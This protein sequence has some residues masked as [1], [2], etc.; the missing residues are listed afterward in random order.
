MQPLSV[1]TPVIIIGDTH[2]GKHGVI[3]QYFSLPGGIVM[4]RVLLHDGSFIEVLPQDLFRTPPPPPGPPPP[5]QQSGPPQYLPPPYPPPPLQQSGPPPQYLPP[6][7]PPPPLQQPGPPPVQLGKKAT[8]NAHKRALSASM[9]NQEAAAATG[10]P[11]LPPPLPPLPP[12]SRVWPG[13]PPSSAQEMAAL[14]PYLEGSSSYKTLNHF[15]DYGGN[16]SKTRR[17]QSKRNRKNKYSRR[18][19]NAKSRSK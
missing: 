12:P 4:A 14:K 5:L 19:R 3:H 16:K 2:Y 7:Y 1:G 18:R 6:P 17:R 8:E 13:P 11:P 9:Q 10:P 15:S